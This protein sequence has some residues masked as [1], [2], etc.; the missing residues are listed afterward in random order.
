MKLSIKEFRT[1][2]ASEWHRKSDIE[3]MQPEMRNCVLFFLES[4]PEH[5]R[6]RPAS[7]RDIEMMV[8]EHGTTRIRKEAS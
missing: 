5:Q 2:Y 8:L 6:E 3:R 1:G 7:K 4:H